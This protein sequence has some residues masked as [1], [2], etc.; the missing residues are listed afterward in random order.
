MEKHTAYFNLLEQLAKPGCPVCAQVRGS[1][2]SFLDSYLYEGVTDRDNWNRLVASD[3]YCARHCSM[4]EKFSDGLAVALF[5]SHLVGLRLEGLGRES[6]KGGWFSAKKETRCPA[7]DYEADTED[8]QVRLLV[9]AMEESEFRDAYRKNDGVCLLHA[10][11]A[12]AH[13]GPGAE[14]V[15]ELVRKNLGSLVDELNEFVRKSDHRNDEKMGPEGDSW[16]RVLRRF[17][18]IRYPRGQK[19]EEA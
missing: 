9:R 5:Y 6:K 1:L 3:G 14:A 12:A 19:D 15:K 16:Q 10:R 2:E 7:C 17:H 8:S 11:Q 13:A 18:G 4:L